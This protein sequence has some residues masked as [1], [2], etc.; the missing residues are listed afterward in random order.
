MKLITVME[1]MKLASLKI[2]TKEPAIQRSV[3]TTIEDTLPPL[4]H[5]VAPESTPPRVVR[6]LDVDGV[7]ARSL[8][9]VVEGFEKAA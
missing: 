9:K 8:P 4:I 6:R 5:A 3:P 2:V 7:L 1:K